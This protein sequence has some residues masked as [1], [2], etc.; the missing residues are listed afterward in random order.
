MG[1]VTCEIETCA[2]ASWRTISHIKQI[3]ILNLGSVMDKDK[4]EK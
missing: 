2:V 1:G 3:R 4:L